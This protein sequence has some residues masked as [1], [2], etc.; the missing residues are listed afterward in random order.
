MRRKKALFI[1]NPMYGYY[2]NIILELE[3]HGWNVDYC[4]DKPTEN[5]FFKG[6]MKIKK[7]LLKPLV[8]KYFDK[9]ISEIK[10]KNYDLVFITNCKVFTT[11]MIK[12]MRNIQKSAR[13]VL[14]MWDSLKLYPDNIDLIP[15]FDDAYSFDLEDCE[16]IDGLKF[17]PLF[18][19]RGFEKVGQ[20]LEEDVKYDIASVCTAHPNRYK[21]MRVLFPKLEANGVRIFSYMYLNKLQYLY[22]RVRV[23][24][25]KGVKSNE[26]KFIP[27]SEKENLEVLKRSN[28]VFDI[29]HINQSGLTMRTIETLGAR[30]KM[31][32]TN[33]DIKKYDFYNENNI[34][35][36]DEWNLEEIEDFINRKYEPI[37]DEVYRKYS[38]SNWLDTII[39]DEDNKYL[40][41]KIG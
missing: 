34:F 3:L 41:S 33:V 31:I 17:L 29:P 7:S 19:C 15:L 5:S 32:T 30:R 8:K 37:D 22:N 9:L 21:I 1:C 10:E 27:L 26:F 38:V 36:M 12:Q 14:Y 16:K 35:V 23:P 28:N 6:M 13:F 2:K 39:N 4:N 24:E 25:F 18:Y 11:E 40:A 20:M